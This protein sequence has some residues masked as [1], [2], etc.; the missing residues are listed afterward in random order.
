VRV[1]LQFYAA[2]AVA[3]A[4]DVIN[5]RSADELLNRLFA[6]IYIYMHHSLSLSL[7]LALG[8]SF[9]ISKG[10]LRARR[11][12]DIFCSLKSRAKKYVM[13]GRLIGGPLFFN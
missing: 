13:P 9:R 8:A 12:P 2:A 10:I 6:Y 4:G 5:S 11:L 7:S 1:C 3:L